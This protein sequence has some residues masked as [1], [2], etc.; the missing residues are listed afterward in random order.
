MEYSDSK[1][2]PKI[3][4]LESVYT[5]LSGFRVKIGGIYWPRKSL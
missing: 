4:K 3:F 5:K 1:Y 2:M